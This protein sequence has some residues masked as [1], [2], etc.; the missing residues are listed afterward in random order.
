MLELLAQTAVIGRG[1]AQLI[2]NPLFRKWPTS[3]KRSQLDPVDQAQAIAVS[4]A[5]MD[6]ATGALAENDDVQTA[7]E[8]LREGLSQVDEAGERIVRPPQ[9]AG[10][11]E[12]YFSEGRSR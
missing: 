6:I 11:W 9:S 12:R 3:T 8:W 7:L 5:L 1:L 10:S 2:T 4:P